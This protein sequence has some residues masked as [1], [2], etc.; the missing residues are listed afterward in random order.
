MGDAVLVGIRP[1]DI[2]IV[3]EHEADVVAR[4][5][6]VEPLGNALHVHVR[7]EPGG[8]RLTVVAP[9]DTRVTF[10]DRIGLRLRRDRLHIFPAGQVEAGL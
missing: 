1:H 6:V 5:S 9:A 4:V 10:D 2:A 7:V 8:V 3:D